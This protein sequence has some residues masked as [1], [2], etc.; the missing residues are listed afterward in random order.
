MPGDY[1]NIW[2][3]VGATPA[4]VSRAD[5]LEA[6]YGEHLE[7]ALEQLRE[8]YRKNEMLPPSLMFKIGYDLWLEQD[9][10]DDL[11]VAQLFMLCLAI[12][13]IVMMEVEGGS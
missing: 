8:A 13:K 11:V 2:S 12:R 9:K 10:S 7:I 5:Q 1:P 4:D 3:Q 6:H